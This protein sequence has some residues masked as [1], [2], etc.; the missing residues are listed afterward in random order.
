MSN[1]NLP[2][3]EWR[4]S[5]PWLD[6]VNQNLEAI[7]EEIRKLNGS[8]QPIDTGPVDTGPKTKRLFFAGHQNS[9]LVGQIGEGQH[10][11]L[12]SPKHGFSRFSDDGSFLY[13]PA[14]PTFIGSDFFTCKDADGNVVFV[15]IEIEGAHQ[16]TLSVKSANIPT[17]VDIRPIVSHRHLGVVVE[18][19]YSIDGRILQKNRGPILDL[20]EYAGQTVNIVYKAYIQKFGGVYVKQS[21][22]K[23]DVPSW[24]REITL[25]DNLPKSDTNFTD[26]QSA[27]AALI[28]A[29]KGTILRVSPSKDGSYKV[30]NSEYA[31]FTRSL[32]LN[33]GKAIK[34]IGKPVIDGVGIG[35]KVWLFSVLDADDV[36]FTAVEFRNVNNG[37]VGI[38]QSPCN[39]I[40]FRD[41]ECYN[42]IGQAFGGEAGSVS[43]RTFYWIDCHVDGV[44]PATSEV[45][46]LRRDGF[47]INFRRGSDIG[48]FGGEWKNC[49]S[50]GISLLAGAPNNISDVEIR[51]TQSI[52]N[53]RQGVLI[54][55]SKNTLVADNDLSRNIA[56]GVQIEGNEDKRGENAK[57]LRNVL[58]DNTGKV[59]GI[60]VVSES[61]AWI[62]GTNNSI[63]QDN[64]ISGGN[65]GI[66]LGEG[67]TKS[68]A[69]KNIIHDIDGN[70]NSKTGGIGITIQQ[71][72]KG[73]G[74]KDVAYCYNTVL[75]CG[76]R[77]ASNPG[78]ASN[79]ATVWISSQS[80][81]TENIR[82]FNNILADPVKNVSGLNNSSHV[83]IQQDSLSEH[84]SM[85][86]NCHW[87]GGGDYL[88]PINSSSN[89]AGWKNKRFGKN[90][91]EADPKLDR[92]FIPSKDSPVIGSAKPT[93]S[94]E[95]V[96]GLV[97]TLDDATALFED[98]L[99]TIMG[100]TRYITKVD[101]NKITVDSEFLEEV[102]V[103]YGVY[104]Y[105]PVDGICVNIGAK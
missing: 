92:N 79:G 103:G 32:A 74:L 8:N 6:K 39:R 80:S 64:V 4:G 90:S 17:L 100:E 94:V 65:G 55:Y 72:G 48:I 59:N 85:E 71:S 11:L 47:G 96:D 42:S 57:I 84:V 31:N 29:P 61:G 95:S 101:G 5:F 83:L 22:I 89:L 19:E 10:K 63:V 45:N 37:A 30:E 1:L 23:V 13:I 104:W 34:G 49:A 41:I 16:I 88:F 69:R 91:I 15:D 12:R 46:G 25:N 86:S 18:D 35:K 14:N 67:V 21:S 66:I 27:R 82:G 99:V 24:T 75:R 40:V 58:R 97:L 73:H 105:H 93:A 87:K 38:R 56:T 20:D 78:R 2:D 28:T 43:N 3:I 77:T 36:T 51:W 62:D 52:Y 7:A 60:A 70:P 50:D 68:V 81:N 26:F 44:T 76:N 9:H 53:G 33:S 102:K 54:F 98:D